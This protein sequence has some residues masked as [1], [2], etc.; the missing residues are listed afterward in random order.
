MR[1]G[2]RSALHGRSRRADSYQAASFPRTA[3]THRASRS[4]AV[5][6]GA[7][8]GGRRRLFARFHAGKS[9]ANGCNRDVLPRLP[10]I[11]F[12]IR[13]IWEKSTGN[14]FVKLTSRIQDVYCKYSRT[15]PKE[16]R[17]SRE[18]TPA[19]I[20]GR[21][22]PM[23]ISGKNSYPTQGKEGHRCCLPPPFRDRDCRR[24]LRR[25]PA[26]GRR[27]SPNSWPCTK[28]TNT[29]SPN[30]SPPTGTWPGPRRTS[31]SPAPTPPSPPPTCNAV[32]A[33]RSAALTLLRA[34][35]HRARILLGRETSRPRPTSPERPCQSRS[36]DKRP[37]RGPL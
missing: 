31:K 36:R 14:G 15:D 17:R 19:E 20:I 34:N 7:R 29:C 21:S 13:H 18:G 10:P 37:D 23:G 27:G 30:L 6:H 26:A 5:P 28:V 35:R 1:Y 2:S 8:P 33:R 25:P 4:G 32:K 12:N 9:P 24:R 16:R 3:S 11:Q 22:C